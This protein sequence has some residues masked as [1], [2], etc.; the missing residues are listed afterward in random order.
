M[1]E[2]TEEEIKQTLRDYQKRSITM[3]DLPERLPHEPRSIG[4]K[5]SISFSPDTGA[6][7]I[8]LDDKPLGAA[9]LCSVTFKANEPNIAT[10]ML[11]LITNQIEIIPNE[12]EPHE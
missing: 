1:H 3:H 9:T 10:V 12:R 2:K 11:E 5:I 6:G 4:H 7:L 8:L